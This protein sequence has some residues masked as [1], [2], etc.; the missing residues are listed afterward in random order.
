MLLQAG[1]HID[2]AE[3]HIKQLEARIAELEAEPQWISVKDRLP[4][5][6]VSVLVWVSGLIYCWIEVDCVCD[7]EWDNWNN[8][9]YKVLFWMPQPPPPKE[10][11]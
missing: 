11:A 6:G 2:S 5:E 8:S 9:R 1:L 10:K 7:G 3:T 4:E